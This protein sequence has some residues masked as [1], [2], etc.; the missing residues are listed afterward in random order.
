MG[1]IK[2][3]HEHSVDVDLLTGGV[4][5]DAGCRGFQFSTALRDLGCEVVALDLEDI[6]MP[7]EMERILFMKAALMPKP[8]D[9][10]YV[11]TKDQQ[12]K[13]ISNVGEPVTGVGINEMYNDLLSQGKRVDLLKLDVEGTE[14]FL[15]SDYNF[16]PI[17][18]QISIE[19]HEH[20]FPGLHG[21]AFES[22]IRNL[23]KHYT[24]VK[25]DRYQAHGA[26]WNYWDSL[27]VRRDLL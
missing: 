19:F 21:T 23:Q 24:A 2:Q 25:H 22:C 5:I 27:W 7:D 9:Y 18:R 3:I 6:D 8:G 10:F 1:N 14:Y 20:C 26:G 11:N 15:L 4:V 16:L 17:P 13:F 12:A